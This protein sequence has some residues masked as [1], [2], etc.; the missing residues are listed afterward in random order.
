M[1]K[2]KTV[3]LCSECG[4]DSPKWVGRCP[5]CNAWNTMEEEKISTSSSVSANGKDSK[6]Q[7]LKEFTDLGEQR[8]PTG[9]GELDRVLGGGIVD[10]SLVLVGGDRV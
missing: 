8:K 5:G 10:G 2:L 4:F 1:A 7:L 9:I 3:F 6:P